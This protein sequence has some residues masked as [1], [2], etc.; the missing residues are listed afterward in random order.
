MYLVQ[1]LKDR[2][3]QK[4][5]R[6]GPKR[7]PGVALVTGANKGIGL[8]VVR[9]LSEEGWMVILCA[10]SRESGSQA[11]TKAGKRVVFVELDVTSQTS[12]A[13]AAQEVSGLTGAVD[14]LVNNAAILL[15]EQDQS[16]CEVN[17]DVLR[18]CWETNC[19]GP[20]LTTR[21]LL[22]LL[23]NS[24]AAR[25]INVSTEISRLSRMRQSF[26]AY[27]ISK[28]GLNA[29]TR[30]LSAACQADGIPVNALCPGWVKTDMGGPG[31]TIPIEQGARAIVRL[32]TEVS[33]DITG[34]FI[35]NGR[36]LPW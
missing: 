31:A 33:G 30:Q 12:I 22:P 28:T 5:L 27:C 3:L 21:A 2:L 9:Q 19:L 11:A 20:L 26:P 32:G 7:T 6:Y 8:E 25:V 35:A 10:R 34:M 36:I 17:V 15:R 23:R 14:L 29:V 16:V 1:R 18:Q 4:Q 24:K 13:A